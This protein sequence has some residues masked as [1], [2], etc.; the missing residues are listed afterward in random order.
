MN[1]RPL[2]DFW[3]ASLYAVARRP[4]ARAGHAP[5]PD[6]RQTTTATRERREAGTVQQRAT[7]DATNAADQEQ[8]ADRDARAS[9]KAASWRILSPS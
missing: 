6:P 8:G 3:S 1:D 9:E 7:A 2:L 4:C 5:R